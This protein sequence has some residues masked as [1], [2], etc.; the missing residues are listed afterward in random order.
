MTRDDP[1]AT[2]DVGEK[3]P[4]VS[5]G[6]AT[7]GT[8]VV[9]HVTEWPEQVQTTDFNTG[10]PEFWPPK[11]GE[12]Q[13]NPKMA[14]VITGTVNGETRALW[15]RRYPPN[16]WNAVTEAQKRAHARIEPGSTLTVTTQG[17]EPA[18]EGS[19]FQARTFTAH[20]EMADAFATDAFGDPVAV[21]QP[22]AAPPA[23]DDLSRHPAAVANDA[24]A[25]LKAQQTTAKALHAQGLT[26][27]QIAA[28]GILKAPNGTLLG[29][30]AVQAI[31]NL[32]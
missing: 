32:A 20:L 26:A 24:L 16:L 19:R 25:Q 15:V 10:E 22:V 27:A 23:R 4:S 1:F 7:P 13:G 3:T 9:I 29:A 14:V 8:S 21:P 18:R 6:E 30:E 5:W 28:N 11:N 17:T 2:L 31:L 12:T